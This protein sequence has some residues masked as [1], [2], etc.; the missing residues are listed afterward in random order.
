MFLAWYHAGTA[1]QRRP[2]AGA[3]VFETALPVRGHPLAVAVENAGQAQCASELVEHGFGRGERLSVR[4]ERGG[5]G[6][7]AVAVV[8]VADVR[9][10]AVG[11]AGAA[12]LEQA[13]PGRGDGVAEYGLLAALVGDHRGARAAM[14]EGDL[15]QAGAR[16]QP[17]RL[18][19]GAAGT[20]GQPGRQAPDGEIAL[21][22]GVV[23]VGGDALPARRRGAAAAQFADAGEQR[24]K[25]RVF[26]VIGPGARRERDHAQV[27]A[28]QGRV[29]ARSL[30]QWAAIAVGEAADRAVDGLQAAEVAARIALAGVMQAQAAPLRIGHGAQQ[31]LG[32]V[33]QGHELP[34]GRQDLHQLALGIEAEF[35]AIG[36]APDVL[37][38]AAGLHLGQVAVRRVP[39]GAQ[40]RI[41]R[42]ALEDDAGA[43]G[44]DDLERVAGDVQLR[45]IRQLPAAAD[46]VGG[47]VGTAEGAVVMADDFQAQGAGQ[48]R[49]VGFALVLVAVD[50]I[51]WI[52]GADVQAA[53]AVGRGGT[54]GAAGRSAIA[55]SAGAWRRRG[56]G[57]R[58]AWSATGVR[59]TGGR[60]FETGDLGM[61]SCAQE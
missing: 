30:R 34:A 26:V 1:D 7:A 47:M 56:Q 3:H 23:S 27:G 31:A 28:Q 21:A 58:N 18:H 10:A 32:V 24:G 55:R 9:F 20:A 46:Q 48:R 6:Q 40:R 38:A 14:V 33:L 44:L 36:P 45:F 50:D 51:D 59:R 42:V 16:G 29:V 8:V 60:Q 57:G 37:L 12:H 49:H 17:G 2:G 43:V 54:L 35:A 5:A 39:A 41:V 53:G 4:V 15:V 61:D 22:V 52:A 19:E 11:A 13:I 25:A